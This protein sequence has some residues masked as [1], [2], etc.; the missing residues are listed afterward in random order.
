MGEERVGAAAAADAALGITTL[1]QCTTTTNTQTGQREKGRGGESGR[2]SERS[3]SADCFSRGSG[4]GG[5]G[6]GLLSK[7]RLLSGCCCWCA[8]IRRFCRRQLWLLPCTIGS[9]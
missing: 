2:E 8:G 1:E 7:L 6:G 5:S 3:G 9:R 4:G